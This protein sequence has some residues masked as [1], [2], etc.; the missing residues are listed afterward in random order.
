MDA[1]QIMD[2]AV[3]KAVLLEFFGGVASCS[4]YN[5]STYQLYL[6]L[7]DNTL[8]IHHDVS[9][10]SWIQRDDGSLLRIASVSGYTDVPTSERYTDGCDIFDFGY[11]D[12]LDQI[13]R[14]IAQAIAN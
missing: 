6:D 13:E 1:P 4:Y 2:T 12:W 8:S 11:A 5:G 3:N 10:N 9:N 14:S 7:N